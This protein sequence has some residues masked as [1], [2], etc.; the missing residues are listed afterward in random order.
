MTGREIFAQ[1]H[2]MALMADNY[3]N[4]ETKAAL[5]QAAAILFRHLA[6]A[7]DAEAADLVESAK[8]S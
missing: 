4:P 2:Q 8:R 5:L 3:P 6:L 1:A 7:L